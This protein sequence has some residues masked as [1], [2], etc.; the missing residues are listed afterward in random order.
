[1]RRA[2]TGGLLADDRGGGCLRA[3]AAN[4][5]IARPL[6]WFLK[7]APCEEA[8]RAFAATGFSTAGVNECPHVEE[9]R[10][11]K[12][13]LSPALRAARIAGAQCRC[14]IGC[15]AACR[16]ATAMRHGAAGASSPQDNSQTAACEDA[17]QNSR[18]SSREIIGLRRPVIVN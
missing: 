11:L 12:P 17:P 14:G 6:E 1:M 8:K 4:C 5:G 18:A 9:R 10:P 2:T 13:A 15:I 3:R 16:E 7:N